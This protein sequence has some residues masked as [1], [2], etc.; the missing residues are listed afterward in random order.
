MCTRVRVACHVEPT[1]WPVDDV[2][3]PA[4]AARTDRPSAAL[5][6]CCHRRLPTLTITT[7][8]YHRKSPAYDS[9]THTHLTALFPGLP[10]WAGTRKVRPIWISLEKE[11]VS[12]SGISWAICKSAPR[13]RQITTPAPHHS[14]FLQAGCPSCRPTNSVKALKGNMTVSGEVKGST[15]V[16]G[17]HPCTNLASAENSAISRYQPDLLSCFVTI[18]LKIT[19]NLN[20]SY[21]ACLH[22]FNLYWEAKIKWSSPNFG[23]PPQN[24]LSYMSQLLSMAFWEALL[25]EYRKIQVSYVIF[26]W[27]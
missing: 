1:V 16:S 21:V 4:T 19:Q 27:W 8:R 5:Q 11:T 23:R 20:V 25:A 22:Q 14:V 2:T 13:S 26:V 9:F 6:Y 3:R 7:A 10:G 17:D 12:G 15:T 24:A 18:H